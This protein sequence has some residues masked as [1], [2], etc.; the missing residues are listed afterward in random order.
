M[1]FALLKE[2]LTNLICAS[3]TLGIDEKKREEWQKMLSKIP[4][5]EINEDGAIKEWL[6]PDF[7]DNYHHRHQ[8]HIYP[9]FPGFEVNEQSNKEL[10]E[11]M[12][13]AVEKRL[14][15]GLKE[16]TG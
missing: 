10:F 14:C 2:L 16:Q 5:Y 7:K 15:I 11:A 9:L 6:H 4:D 13:V 8:S 3:R 1:D 12:K